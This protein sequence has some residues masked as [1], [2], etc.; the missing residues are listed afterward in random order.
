MTERLSLRRARAA[1]KA[2]EP[3]R[4][5]NLN[6]DEKRLSK[7]Y[8]QAAESLPA[9][10]HVCCLVPALAMLLAREKKGGDALFDDMAG[11]LFVECGMPVPGHSPTSANRGQTLAKLTDVDQNLYLVLKTEALEYAG[12]LKRFAQAFIPKEA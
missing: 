3:R 6:H 2:S 8:R 5:P 9:D 11:W 1:L 7:E 10:I 12:W 4:K